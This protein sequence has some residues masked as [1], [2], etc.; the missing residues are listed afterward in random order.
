MSEPEWPQSK[1]WGMRYAAVLTGA[2]IVIGLLMLAVAH[3]L[4]VRESPPT[5]TGNAPAGP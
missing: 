4:P 5:A 2:I 3:Q 1:R